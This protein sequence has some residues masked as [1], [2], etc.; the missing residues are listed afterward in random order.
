MN[1]F[2]LPDRLG[3]CTASW[4]CLQMEEAA[5]LPANQHPTNRRISMQLAPT[6]RSRSCVNGVATSLTGN[7]YKDVVESMR[8]KIDVQLS[9][10]D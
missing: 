3:Y 10:P 4:E 2:D 8:T 1:T 7:I 9:G 5:L 6:R